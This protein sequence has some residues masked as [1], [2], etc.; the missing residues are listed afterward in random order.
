MQIIFFKPVHAMLILLGSS[1][2]DTQYTK[3]ITEFNHA[4][5]YVS[6]RILY[7]PSNHELACILQD[8]KRY[9]LTKQEENR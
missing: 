4:T 5:I 3:R 1:L 6:L 2:R 9:E 8:L 7:I